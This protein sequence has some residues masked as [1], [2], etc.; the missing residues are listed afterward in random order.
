LN[1]STTTTI[2]LKDVFHCPDMGL[3]L[4]SIGKITNASYKV[5]FQGTTCI[6][7][8]SKDKIIGQVNARNRLYWMD[9]K[10]AVNIAMAGED[11]EIPTIEELHH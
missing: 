8:N 7:Y 6:I 1:G 10:V 11:Q 9:H 3:T 5:I 4:V 2:L